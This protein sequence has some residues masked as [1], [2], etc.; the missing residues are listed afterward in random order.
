MARKH[1]A[2]NTPTLVIIGSDNTAAIHSLNGR[3]VLFDKET[4]ALLLEAQRG[5]HSACTT[6]FSGHGRQSR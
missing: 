2:S 4:D 5:K 6:I 1:Y 3:I